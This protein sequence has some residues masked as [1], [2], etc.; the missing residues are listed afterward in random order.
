MHC[1]SRILSSEMHK[2]ISKPKRVTESDKYKHS[3][4]D[5]PN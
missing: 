3:T 1:M 2:A 5:M 4:L